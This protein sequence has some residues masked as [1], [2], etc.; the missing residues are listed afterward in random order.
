MGPGPGPLEGL[1]VV[2]FVAASDDSDAVP[3]AIAIYVGV[4]LLFWLVVALPLLATQLNECTSIMSAP[5]SGNKICD[6]KLGHLGHCIDETFGFE[7]QCKRGFEPLSTES[8]ER[9][10]LSKGAYLHSLQCPCVK[11]GARAVKL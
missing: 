4:C 6:D 1:G 7:C 8:A 9:H 5:N 10:V 3:Q 2:A 11:K